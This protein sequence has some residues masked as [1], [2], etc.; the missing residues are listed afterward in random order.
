M[1]IN[2]FD[3]GDS[4]GLPIASSSK[5]GGVKVGSNLTINSSGILSATQRSVVNNLTSTST[6]SALTAYQGKV[7]KDL[8]DGLSGGGAFVYKSQKC[9][10]TD[11][12]HKITH[13][14][15]AHSYTM[16]DFSLVHILSSTKTLTT[17]FPSGEKWKFTVDSSSESFPGID[18]NSYRVFPIYAGCQETTR[19][20]FAISCDFGYEVFKPYYTLL[21][22]T[23]ETLQTITQTT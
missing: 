21:N 10:F 17:P 19:G 22:T 8:I 11:T 12:T 6:T 23:G 1:K 20:N 7:L 3:G 14:C 4:Y 15:Y 5:L 16:G 18:T 9:S 13:S 2:Y